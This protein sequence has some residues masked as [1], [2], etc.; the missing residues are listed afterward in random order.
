MPRSDRAGRVAQH[1]AAHSLSDDT[2]ARAGPG[3]MAACLRHRRACGT[4]VLHGWAREPI[5]VPFP[6]ACSDLGH[7]IASTD[8]ADARRLHRRLRHRTRVRA[9]AATVGYRAAPRTTRDLRHG[10]VA[11]AVARNRL[12]R[13]ACLADHRGIPPARRRVGGDRIG[14]C[15]RTAFVPARW[16]GRRRRP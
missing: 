7:R 2:T 13:L 4:L 14:A 8:D 12:H 5:R 6:R 16:A 9:R 3:G 15:T 10:G 1:C 11:I